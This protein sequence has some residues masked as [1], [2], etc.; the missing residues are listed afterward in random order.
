MSENINYDSRRRRGEKTERE[1]IGVF[2]LFDMGN[3]FDYLGQ[4]GDVSR[5]E[6]GT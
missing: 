2:D 1:E 5:R 3:E 4:P 6:Y